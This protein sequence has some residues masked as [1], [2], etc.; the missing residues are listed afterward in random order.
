MLLQRICQ[1]FRILNCNL[2]EDRKNIIIRRFLLVIKVEYYPRHC[3]R[4]TLSRCTASTRSTEFL[5]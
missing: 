3:M 5:G 1:E 2:I 4:L